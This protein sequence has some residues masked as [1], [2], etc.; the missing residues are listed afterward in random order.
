[1]IDSSG[2]FVIQVLQQMA[3]DRPNSDPGTPPQKILKHPTDDMRASAMQ[4]RTARMP[5]STF[6]MKGWKTYIQRSKLNFLRY[7]DQL[8]Q[9]NITKIE[10]QLGHALPFLS[11]H[12]WLPANAR[13]IWLNRKRLKAIMTQ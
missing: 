12:A 1:V 5:P 8:G 13:L 9:A 3:Q 4:N 7:R 6:Q 10:R 2:G 11:S